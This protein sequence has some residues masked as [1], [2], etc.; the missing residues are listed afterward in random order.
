M[1]KLHT[2]KKEESIYEMDLND[3]QKNFCVLRDY[4]WKKEKW[5]TFTAFERVKG[6]SLKTNPAELVKARERRGPEGLL[7]LK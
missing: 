2:K 3:D 7:P 5:M 1:L 4:N 6:G